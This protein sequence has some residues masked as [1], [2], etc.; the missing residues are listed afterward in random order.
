[1]IKYFLAS[2]TIPE[3]DLWVNLSPYEKDRIVPEFFGQTE[4]GRDLLAEDYML[5]QITASL[6][7]PEDEVGKKFWKRIYEEAAKKYGTT[8][9]PVN[10]FNKVWIVPEKAVVY[11]NAKVGAVYVVESKLKIML[12]QDYLSL[13]K[14][15]GIQ[16]KSAD[17][18]NTSQLGSDI[19]REVV[20]PELTKE[21]NENKNFSQ[22]RQVY[23]SLILAT[24]YKKKIKDS[25]LSQV[26]RDRNKVEGVNIDNPQEKQKIYQQYLQAFK[27]GVYN[28]IK[29]DVDPVTQQVR[30]RKYFSGG[31]SMGVTDRILKI[32]DNAMIGGESIKKIKRGTLLLVTAGLLFSL[33]GENAPVKHQQEQQVIEPYVNLD[34]ETE[35]I[36]LEKSKNESDQINDKNIFN[37]IREYLAPYS[38]ETRHILVRKFNI[39]T[40]RRIL[41]GETNESI[42]DA[43]YIL[44]QGGKYINKE[45]ASQLW[46]R[47]AGEKYSL[48]T[49]DKHLNI[50]ADGKDGFLEMANITKI[51]LEISRSDLPWDFRYKFSNFIDSAKGIGTYNIREAY[52]LYSSI[53]WVNKKHEENGLSFISIYQH[54]HSSTYRRFIDAIVSVKGGP[55]KILELLENP[56]QAREIFTFIHEIRHL[57][58]LE[59]YVVQLSDEEIV[60]CINRII[61][62]RKQEPWGNVDPTFRKRLFNSLKSLPGGLDSFVNR[63][64]IPERLTGEYI[65]SIFEQFANVFTRDIF[66]DALK[67]KKKMVLEHA[68]NFISLKKGINPTAINMFNYLI[69]DEDVSP[70]QSNVLMKYL[71]EEAIK[72]SQDSQRNIYM[73]LLNRVLKSIGNDKMMYLEKVNKQMLTAIREANIQV[74][75]APTLIYEKMKKPKKLKVIM[76]NPLDTNFVQERFLNDGFKREKDGNFVLLTKKSNGIEIQVRLDPSGDP[77]NYEGRIFKQMEDP[78]IDM[79]IYSGHTGM[80]AA[81]ALA[82]EESPKTNL[83]IGGQKII[84]I[85]SCESI[86]VYL[87]QTLKRYPYSHVY[88]T[89]TKSYME[90][91][92]AALLIFVNKLTEFLPYVD[93]HKQIEDH[94]QST[95]GGRVVYLGPHQKKQLDYFYLDGYGQSAQKDNPNRI[96]LGNEKRVILR[97]EDNFNFSFENVDLSK[98]QTDIVQRVISHLTYFYGFNDYLK[99]FKDDLQNDSFWIPT[100]D[101][102][103]AILMQD[104]KVDDKRIFKLSLN[105]GYRNSSE[106]VLTMMALYESNLYFTKLKNNKEGVEENIGA[107]DKLRG[108]QMVAEFVKYY[109]KESLFQPFLEKYGFREITLN[110][111]LRTLDSHPTPERIDALKEILPL[112]DLPIPSN[113]DEKKLKEE[114]LLSFMT[115]SSEFEV[116]TA[117]VSVKGNSGLRENIK[118]TFSSADD[119]SKNGPMA[120]RVSNNLARYLSGSDSAMGSNI[121]DLGGIDLTSDK[122]MQVKNDGN[123][124]IKF[125]LDPTQLAQLQNASGFTPVIIGIQPMTDIKLFLGLNDANSSAVT[126]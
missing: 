97:G 64:K 27:K 9:I 24:W 33:G 92:T 110:Q 94:E 62:V 79:I 65:E 126:T 108:L 7:Y 49:F 45:Q 41:Y 3:K 117:S 90:D 83:L 42:G 85:F 15:E 23:N 98:V 25:I 81:L 14:H 8:D 82:F 77:K 32:M 76:Y 99:E 107:F 95:Y 104:G 120:Y 56:Q 22:L 100:D 11:E 1:M 31:A 34:L 78:S 70:E 47:L 13:E 61:E 103:D 69:T 102:E 116:Q 35:R 109:H 6:I 26:Y 44:E 50:E 71:Y 114:G 60:E 37:R 112:L 84:G 68:L 52:Q 18:K 119:F 59:E 74:R 121:R 55:I 39:K 16:S 111:L 88:G 30:P 54:L 86:P 57:E 21:I 53:K 12:E 105:A 48:E 63:Q 118:W 43:L 89:A 80:G 115:L 5:K 66:R 28:F 124:E 113:V 46:K 67:I 4:M 2:L 10:T 106:A 125:H 40:W 73:I 38:L 36:L 19:V 58:S 75:T 51:F 123:G 20:I 17:S 91:D 29:E 72:E 93:I 122:A 101:K 87:S 96:Y